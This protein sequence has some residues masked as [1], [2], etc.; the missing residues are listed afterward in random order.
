MK[1]IKTTKKYIKAN[2]NYIFN[3]S[4]GNTDYLL[5]DIEPRFYNAGVYG[6]NWN[7]YELTENICII[8]GYRNTLGENISREILAIYEQ[9]AKKIF[10]TDNLTY[11]KKLYEIK[12]LRNEFI[13]QILNIK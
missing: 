11:D 13:K 3:A 9:Q 7:G 6:W 5:M 2:Y 4:G 8:T 12:K 1:K 10:E